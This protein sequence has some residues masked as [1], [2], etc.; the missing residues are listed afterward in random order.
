M[1]VLKPEKKKKAKEKPNSLEP[2]IFVFVFVWRI[3]LSPR[4]SKFPRTSFLR[5]PEASGA[6]FSWLSSLWRDPLEE[7]HAVVGFALSGDETQGTSSSPEGESQCFRLLV[8]MVN[9]S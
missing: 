6:Y 8:A 7:A 2:A 5:Q 9:H 3:S 1:S 4:L